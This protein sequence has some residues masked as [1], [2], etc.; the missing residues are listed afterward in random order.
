LKLLSKFKNTDARRFYQTFYSGSGKKHIGTD[1]VFTYFIYFFEIQTE[2]KIEDSLWN[3]GFFTD[4]LD[5]DG[6]LKVGI[7]QLDR[8]FTEYIDMSKHSIKMPEL[9]ISGAELSSSSESEVT[10][11][12]R[13]RMR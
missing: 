4:M 6:N 5:E 12:L 10:T 7:E 3:Q 9:H 11:T 13:Y 1:E 2:R 8:F